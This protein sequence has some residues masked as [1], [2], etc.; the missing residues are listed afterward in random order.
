M[1]EEGRGDRD[2]ERL[3]RAR[4]ADREHG[5]AL[6]LH[7]GRDALALVPNDTRYTPGFLRRVLRFAIPTGAITSL[8]IFGRFAAC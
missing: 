1:H 5:L 4:A 2:V 6:L 7:A 8:A 3:D